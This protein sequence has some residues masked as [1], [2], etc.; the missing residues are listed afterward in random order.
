MKYINYSTFVRLYGEAIKSSNL[1]L[2]V[3]ERG[4]QEEWMGDL[5]ITE[6]INILEKIYFLANSSLPEI[7][8]NY[9][10]SRSALSRKY[11]I[12]YRTLQD[13]EKGARIAPAYVTTMLYYT[14][15]LDSINNPEGN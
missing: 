1:D 14:L 6:I 15:L 2:F 3:S 12:P 11:Y 4:W 7:R 9:N 10:Y 13:W 8:K 5:E